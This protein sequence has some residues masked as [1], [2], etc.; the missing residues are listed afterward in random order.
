MKTLFNKYWF[1]NNTFFSELSSK[2]GTLKTS[3]SVP[4]KSN[5]YA[6]A[7]TA[8]VIFA[9]ATTSPWIA[10]SSNQSLVLIYCGA[11]TSY[12]NVIYARTFTILASWIAQFGR[13]FILAVHMSMFYPA[14]STSPV[15]WKTWNC[16]PP[17]RTSW[18]SPINLITKKLMTS[19]I[20]LMHQDST[21]SYSI[22]V[23]VVAIQAIMAWEVTIKIDLINQLASF[24]YW[25][26]LFR[27]GPHGKDGN[28]F[29][30][31]TDIN[32]LHQLQWPG[33]GSS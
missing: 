33:R 7:V 20:L 18:T 14:L 32:E 22:T 29:Q 12:S 21:T 2:L 15:A 16:L 31:S 23:R 30:R 17:A 3:L 26:W 27:Q 4:A 19:W 11:N 10:N 5:T 6:S 25:Q 9:P 13:Q 28:T 24:Q 1:L 8:N